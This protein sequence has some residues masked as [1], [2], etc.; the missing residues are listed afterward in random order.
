MEVV[1][2]GRG[3]E[4]TGCGVHQQEGHSGSWEAVGVVNIGRGWEAAGG[5]EATEGGMHRCEGG[6]LWSAAHR[7]EGWVGMWEAAGLVH[8][9]GGGLCQQEGWAEEAVEG[10]CIGGRV[11]WEGGACRAQGRKLLGVHVVGVGGEATR[12]GQGVQNVLEL[13]NCS[14]VIWDFQYQGASGGGGVK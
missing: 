14:K 8:V 6:K 3:W 1:C 5:W 4:A 12:S 13:P 10:V 9:G 2:I 11:G 7:Q